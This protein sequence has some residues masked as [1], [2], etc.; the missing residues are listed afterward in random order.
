[1]VSRRLVLTPA[2]LEQRLRGFVSCGHLGRWPGTHP[3]SQA[4]PPAGS[5]EAGTS[6]VVSLAPSPVLPVVAVPSVFVYQMTQ[7]PWSWPRSQRVPWA[8]RGSDQRQVLG[9]SLLPHPSS[10]SVSYFD[11]LTL[12]PN[13][14][15]NC[16][17]YLF[18]ILSL[19]H[20]RWF[21]LLHGRPLGICFHSPRWLN[22]KECRRWK[23]PGFDPWVR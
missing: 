10:S 23:R 22:G 15:E 20:Y 5:S 9:N 8:R 18:R 2:S 4:G 19:R 11:F 17:Q 1:M 21:V 12:S 13:S 3:P 14:V 6:Y 16:G 7:T